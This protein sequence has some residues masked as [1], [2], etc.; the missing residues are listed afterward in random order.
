MRA[1]GRVVRPDEEIIRD[2]TR[3]ITNQKN[4][5]E[6]SRDVRST[7]NQLR[8]LDGPLWGNKTQNL[9]YFG[10]VVTWVE[11]L[12]TTL[13]EA[14]N[15]A[16]TLKLRRQ[17]EKL[18][19]LLDAGDRHCAFVLFAPEESETLDSMVDEA[20]G[21]GVRFGIELGNLRAAIDLGLRPACDGPL[22]R[23]LDD[24]RV[25]SDRLRDGAPGEHGLSGYTQK[26]AAIAAKELM[27]RWSR[28]PGSTDRE[29]P[30]RRIASLL[31]EAMTGE[32][33]RDMERA[34]DAVLRIQIRTK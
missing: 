15:A 8:E 21:R 20:D 11:K 12:Q 4:I 19:K 32:A 28:R 1:S 5:V 3:K 31:Y 2:I 24:L 26:Q 22:T 29:S 23:G 18:V 33:D 17:I 34:C 10:K 30:F 7:I 9:D 27:E 14:P 16:N 13:V 25:R 6:I